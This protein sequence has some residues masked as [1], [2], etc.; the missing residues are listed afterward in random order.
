MLDQLISIIAFV[1]LTLA[2]FGAGRPLV[3]GLRIDEEDRLSTVVWSIALGLIVAGLLLAGLG[4]LSLLY[5]PLIVVLTVVAAAWGVWEIVRERLQS[6]S[7][8]S[9]P[10]EEPVAELGGE[11][12]RLLVCCL[13]V[14]A[15]LACVGSLIGALAPP[16]AGDALCYHLELPKA[17]LLEHKLAY[18]PYNDNSTFPLLT[19]MWFMW[20][21]A[22]GGAVC[23]QLVHWGLG[24]LLAAAAVLLAVPI[25]GRRW[26][27]AAGV[28][29]L[30]T[31]G[32]NNQMTAP[33][34]DVAL[35]AMTTLALAAWYRAVVDD[36][37]RRWLLVAGIAGGAAMATKYIAVV[38]AAAV[39]VTWI[40]AMVRR[41]SQRHFLL[42][43]VAVVAVVAVSIGGLWY[44]RAAWHRGNP[45]YPFLGE[46]FRTAA[47]EP[48]KETLPPSKSPLGRG[49]DGLAVAPWQVTMHPE[50]FGGRGHQLGVL[51]LAVLPGLL[52]ARK[53]RGLGILLVIAAAYFVFWFMLRQNVRFL[54]PIVPLLSVAL[55]WVW[56]E[57]SRLGRR[58]RM[59]ATMV[60]A[61]TII[62]LAVVPLK[63]SRAQ[64]RVAVGLEDREDYLLRN[65]PAYR[66]AAVANALIK[67]HERMLSQDYRAF[68]FNNRVTRENIYR[69]VEHYDRQVKKPSDL[70]D[71]LLA[72]GF[73]YVLL[74]ETIPIDPTHYDPTLSRLVDA[75]LRS[76]AAEKLLTVA[77]Y[78]T[79]DAEGLTRRYRLM[80]L[81]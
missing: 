70:S 15:F 71:H 53:L 69:R 58:P 34:N 33:L 37:G 42:E 38:F 24:I 26:A 51:L 9:E 40:W 12:S 22:T 67:P 5:V 21:L 62:V 32:I 29:V 27:L 68:Y 54:F 80:M 63:R 55:V 35:A 23:A 57:M 2:A 46:V 11:P 65:E 36:H 78:Q 61:G 6:E 56:M 52:L 7:P 18:L 19:E 41:K 47:S 28:V 4:L 17:F 81:R 74:A 50:R 72:A 1:G 76:P 60:L 10:D 49:L 20:G 31:P 77:E 59:V 45:V 66:A 44:V 13:A 39:A 16:T 48:S 3:R 43:A 73:K 79:S 75:Q 25:I 30:L 64:F 8:R 14:V